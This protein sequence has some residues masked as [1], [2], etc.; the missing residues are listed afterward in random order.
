MQGE[1]SIS[2][3]LLLQLEF[4]YYLF[5]VL[6]CLFKR[7]KRENPSKNVRRIGSPQPRVIKRSV[8]RNDHQESLSYS[9]IIKSN[10]NQPAQ[11][12]SNFPEL[13]T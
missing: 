3:L 1:S 5:K 13:K 9:E 7:S 12:I 4:G 6:G 10:S 2:I 11:I 8:T